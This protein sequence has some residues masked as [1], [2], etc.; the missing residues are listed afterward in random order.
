ML[1]TNA[2]HDHKKTK[3]CLA[4]PNYERNKKIE[5]IDVNYNQEYVLKKLIDPCT[6]YRI[7]NVYNKICAVTEIK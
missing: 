6:K 3:L 2:Y 5:I 7:K 1:A 4:D